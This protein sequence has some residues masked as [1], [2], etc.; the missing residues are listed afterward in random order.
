MINGRYH[1][2]IRWDEYGDRLGWYVTVVT[3]DGRHSGGVKIS[4]P[5]APSQERRFIDQ[6]RMIHRLTAA[7]KRMIDGRAHVYRR[8]QTLRKER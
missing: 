1:L 3:D 7:R 6:L 4:W 5:A 2:T 8:W